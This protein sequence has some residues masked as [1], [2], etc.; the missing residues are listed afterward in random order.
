LIEGKPVSGEDY[1]KL[2]ETVRNE[3]ETKQADL[4]KKLQT[5]FEAVQEIESRTA[6]KIR[7]ND[8]AVADFTVSK[9][10]DD[11]IKKF[12]KFKDVTKYIAELRSYTLNNQDIFIKG[13]EKVESVLGLPASYIKKG[14]DP[15]IPFQINVF[16]DNSDTKGQPV[17]IESNPNY[18]NLFGKI[19]RRF[20]L[21][22]YL[23]DHTMLKAGSMQLANGGY[24]LLAATDV[25]ANPGVWPALKRTIKTKEITIEDSLEQFGL[26]AP[27]GLRP[28]P[29]PID[30][31]ILL[32]GDGM[33]YQLLSMHDEDFWEIFKVKA[34]FDYEIARTKENMIHFAA[35]VAGC[36]EKC[37]IHHFDRT[38]VAKTVE[39]A[40]RMVADQEKLTS[41]FAQIRELV[42]EAEYWA[43]RDGAS[44]VSAQHVDKA[45]E[46]RYFRHNLPDEKIREMIGN[47]TIM[48]DIDGAVIGQVN[49]LAVYSLGD[50]SFGRPS[51]ITC[52]T[53]LGRGGVINIERESQLSGRIHDKGVLILSGYMGWKYAQDK[54]LSLSASLCFEQSYDGIDGDSASSTELYALLS[55]L[56]GVPIKQGIAITGSVNQTGEIQPIGGVNQKIEGFFRVCK[57]K[58][59]N[60]EQGVMIPHQ[61][62]KNLMLRQ[63]IMDATQ[64]GKFHVYAVS[65]IDEGI[66]ILTGVEAGIL[67]NGKYPKDSINYEVDKCLKEMAVKLRKFAEPA[68]K[69]KS[70]KKCDCT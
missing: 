58:G 20:L 24:L 14:G 53:F 8:S 39:Y 61:N 34:D 67:R 31:K 30:T 1:I 68:E 42:Q 52:K 57:A 69:E 19:E 50:I 2:D 12:K 43:T 11:L 13:E 41:R 36:C 25:L 62:I 4:L 37:E 10:Y 5:S 23:S 38:G 21:G 56:S 54:P 60:G 7:E 49:G 33:I 66:E 6:D 63:E 28:R 18:A 17:I 64:Q 59:L 16:V 46:E 27:Q 26:M 22:G 55:S 3:I 47:G 15:F 65:T 51:R 35:F 45:V 48:I 9:L 40:S 70:I 44:L 29:I 32:I